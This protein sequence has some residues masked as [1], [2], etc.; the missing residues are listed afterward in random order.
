MVPHTEYVLGFWS[1]SYLLDGDDG[2]SPVLPNSP[3]TVTG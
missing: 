1:A 2:P 3:V